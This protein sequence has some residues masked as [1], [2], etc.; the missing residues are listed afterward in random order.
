[1]ELLSISFFS[2]DLNNLINNKFINSNISGGFKE[3][4]NLPDPPPIPGLGGFQ[5]TVKFFI[6]FVVIF[7][8][9]SFFPIIIFG[10]MLYFCWKYFNI[11]VLKKVK[12]V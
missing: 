1:M 11:M 2:E 6:L 3:L 12:S 4:D 9:I 7:L 5:S 10:L 8:V